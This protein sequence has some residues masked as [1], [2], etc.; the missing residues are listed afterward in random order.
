VNKPKR[1]VVV[2]AGPNRAGKTTMAPS[3]LKGVLEVAEFVNADVVATGLS[4]FHPERAAIMAGRVMLGRIRDLARQRSS[5]P[6][7]PPSPADRSPFGWPSC[8]EV[9]T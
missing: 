7:K 1:H 2:L 5:L 9:A 3:L 8:A 6:S 4:A